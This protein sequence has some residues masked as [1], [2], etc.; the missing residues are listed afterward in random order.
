M[1]R[2]RRVV[3]ATLIVAL[4]AG[5]T[6][7]LSGCS[8][9]LALSSHQP[10]TEG[11]LANQRKVATEFIADYRHPELESIR[12][13]TEGSV[14]GAGSWG[15]NAVLTVDGKEY[16]GFIGDL[17]TGGTLPKAPPGSTSGDITLIYSDGT[18]EVLK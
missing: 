6:S 3:V 8:I 15:A 18:S 1:T 9:F 2:C 17:S 5:V 12:Y 14:N 4:A 10:S 13:T 16:E 11:N 7:G